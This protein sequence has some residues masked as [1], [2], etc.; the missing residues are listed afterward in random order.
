MDTKLITLC[1]AADR[2]SWQTKDIALSQGGYTKSV[3]VWSAGVIIYILLSGTP[4]FWGETDNDIFKS[5]INDR[6]DLTSSPW[7][8]MSP[9]CKDFM[10]RYVSRKW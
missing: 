9:A 7:H 8:R 2:H 4:P 1:L 3:D 10:S 5:V 6:L